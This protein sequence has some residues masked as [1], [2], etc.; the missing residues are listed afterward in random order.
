MTDWRTSFP[1]ERIDE[2]NA[3][4]ANAI[5]ILSSGNPIVN[6]AAISVFRAVDIML[7]MAI[8]ARDINGIFVG[9][10]RLRDIAGDEAGTTV[11][12]LNKNV[13]AYNDYKES[14]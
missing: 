11:N 2:I 9:T 6:G 5:D 8:L 1:I 10:E 7:E 12:L 4:I 13:E 14:F 3:T